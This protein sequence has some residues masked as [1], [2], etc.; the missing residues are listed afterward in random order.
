[1]RAVVDRDE[2][3]MRTFDAGQALEAAAATTAGMTDTEHAAAVQAWL[4]KARHPRFDRLLR[5][6][7]YQ[8]MRELIDALRG[9]QFKVFLLTAGDAAFVQ[10]FSQALFGIP[11]QRVIGSRIAREG[12]ARGDRFELAAHGP[13]LVEHLAKTLGSH[14]LLAIGNADA[15]LPLLTHAGGAPR[16]RLVMLL[17]HDDAEREYRYTAQSFNARHE[18]AVAAA[19]ANL[20]PMVS[21]KDDW[22]TVF[23]AR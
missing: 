17:R 19:H 8:P 14:P 10:Q 7:T 2:V 21:I 23:A 13:A 9:K 1:M 5:D 3:A 22:K 18:L 20:W 6:T 11:P 4:D 12:N 16:S 15:D